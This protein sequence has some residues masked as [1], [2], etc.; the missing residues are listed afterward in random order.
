MVLCSDFLPKIGSRFDV[1]RSVGVLF[2]SQ[3]R[4]I[5]CPEFAAQDGPDPAG[6][7]PR[8]RDLLIGEGPRYRPRPLAP[9]SLRIIT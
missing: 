7:L 5:G 2:Y 9:D 6:G 3:P 1:R 4:H 8:D